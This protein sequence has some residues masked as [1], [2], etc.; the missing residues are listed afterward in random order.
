MK[1]P[2]NKLLADWNQQFDQIKE[3]KRFLISLG[4]IAASVTLGSIHPLG[5]VVLF[6]LLIWRLFYRYD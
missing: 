4:L 2:L 1:K 3:P 6:L 5:Y